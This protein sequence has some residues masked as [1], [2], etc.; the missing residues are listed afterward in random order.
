MQEPHSERFFKE[1]IGGSQKGRGPGGHSWGLEGKRRVRGLLTDHTCGQ[2]QWEELSSQSQEGCTGFSSPVDWFTAVTGHPAAAASC[3]APHRELA[4]P[5]PL[6]PI[7]LPPFHL[8]PSPQ[9]SLR[10]QAPGARLPWCRGHYF[11]NHSEGLSKGQALALPTALT[12]R[13]KVTCLR[14]NYR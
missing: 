3:V 13:R 12:Q 7:A 5:P 2:A 11:E 10:K 9:P 4:F 1:R 6:P 8:L 14:S